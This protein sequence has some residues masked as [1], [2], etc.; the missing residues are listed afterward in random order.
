MERYTK[1]F[2][3]HDIVSKHYLAIAI[4][5]LRLKVGVQGSERN[6]DNRYRRQPARRRDRYRYRN[7]SSITIF[8][9]DTNPGSDTDS[10]E[11]TGVVP[12]GHPVI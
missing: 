2:Q 11:R 10:D 1:G 5:M 7:R 12:S 8:E 6:S 3:K 9:V 4:N